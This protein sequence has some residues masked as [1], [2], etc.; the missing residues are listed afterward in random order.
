LR[1][2]PIAPADLSVEQRPLYQDMKAGIAAKYSEFQTFRE[3]GAIMGPWN[4][5][6]HEPDVGTA[7]WQL[8][9]AV[10]KFRHLP[11]DIR[12]LV[13]LVVGARFNAAYEI[14]AHSAVA[15]KYGLSDAF[16]ASLLAGEQPAAMTDAQETAYLAANALTTGGVLPETL[17]RAAVRQFGQKGTHEIIYLVGHYSLVSMT[18]NGFDVP[19][20]A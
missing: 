3:D 13:I 10:T 18:L 4:A 17:F 8:T 5:W 9:K 2:P 7:V 1:L 20:P 16:L 19:V 6:L 11:D 12:Q 15:K 14:Y